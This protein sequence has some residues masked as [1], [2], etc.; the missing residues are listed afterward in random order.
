MTNYRLYVGTINF[1]ESEDGWENLHLDASPRAIWHDGLKISVQPEFVCSITSMPMFRKG[2]FDEIIAHHVLEH[3]TEREVNLALGELNRILKK[4]CALDIEVPDLDRLC[5]AWVN[6]D[7][8]EAGLL[9][10]FYSEDLPEM[11][12][13][14][15]NAHRSGWTEKRLYD[16]LDAAGFIVGDRVETGLALRVKAFK[17]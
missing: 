6:G 3:L 8:D 14:L 4:D 10:W 5:Q 12:D 15:L 2:M 16:A 1:Y 17:R 7:Y 11:E 9:Q 13:P